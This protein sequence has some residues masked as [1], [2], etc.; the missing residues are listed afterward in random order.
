M[1]D[2]DAPPLRV[3]EIIRTLNRSGVE[4]IVIGG[5]AAAAHGSAQVTRDLD[6]TP[7]WKEE[8][9]DRL[10]DALKEMGAKLRS[11]G[12]T[13]SDRELLEVPLDGKWLQ[14]ISISTWRTD[15]GDVDVISSTPRLGGGRFVYED[16]L[17]SRDTMNSHGLTISVVGLDDLIESKRALRRPRDLAMLDELYRIRNLKSLDEYHEGSVGESPET[18]DC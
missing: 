18:K 1:S 6:I 14:N 15:Y 7:L 2:P 5:L 12:R 13:P 8:N 16:L 4:Y 3:D 17:T 11:G 10:A 9:L